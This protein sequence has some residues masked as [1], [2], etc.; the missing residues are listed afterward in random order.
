DAL[1]DQ[2]MRPVADRGLGNAE[3]GGGGEPHTTS[4][5]GRVFPWKEGQDRPGCADL[6]AVVKMIGA[7]IIEVD[8]LFHEAEA[9]HAR[10]ELEIVGRLAGYG[11]DVMNAVHCYLRS[12]SWPKRLKVRDRLEHRS[13]AR[14]HHPACTTE[15]P[16]EDLRSAGSVAKALLR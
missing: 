10:V 1:I 6:I 16:H 11:S 8:R 7:R 12:S 15:R 5:G 13:K 4:P 2:T 3:A 14:L 9:Q